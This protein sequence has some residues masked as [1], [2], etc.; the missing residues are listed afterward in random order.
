MQ[1]AADRSHLCPVCEKPNA[2][3][4][5]ATGDMDAPCWCRTAKVPR[6][7]LAKLPEEDRNTRC[8]CQACIDGFRRAPTIPDSEGKKG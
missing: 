7:L 8:V 3:A 1:P 6:R 2:C 5:A 4:L